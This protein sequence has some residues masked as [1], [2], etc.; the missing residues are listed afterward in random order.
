M[1][2]L[3][4]VRRLTGPNLLWDKPGA[5]VD[6][7]L[8][9][10]DKPEVLAHWNKWIERLLTDFGWQA[11]SHTYRE[12]EHGFNFAIS[13][14]IDALYT[15]C[16]VAELAWHCCASEVQQ[17]ALPDWKERMRALRAELVQEQNPLML[18]IIENAGHHNVSCLFDDDELSL[19]MGAQQDR[20]PVDELPLVDKIDWAKYQ[21]IPCAFITGTNGKST[22]VRLASQIAKAQGICAGV[23]STD[24]IRVGDVIIE[25]GDYSG[26]GGARMLLRDKR[27]EMAFLEVARGGILRRGLPVHHV[28][29]ALI[30]NV[31]SDHLGQYGIY[32]VEALAQT[33]FVVAKALSKDGVLVVNAD[34]DLV[35]QH[36]KTLKNNLCWFSCGEFNS[37]VQQQISTGGRAVFVRSGEV[38]YHQN[39][40]YQAICNI[41]DIPMTLQGAASHNVQN[42]LGVV[43]L[44]KALGLSNEAIVSGLKNFGSDALDNPGRGNIYNINGSQ[45]IVDFAHNE[46][47]M[48]AVVD[49]ARH[50]PANKYVAMFSHAGDRSDQEIF[51]LTDA[52][53][54]LNA[55][56]YIPAEVEKYLR[57]RQPNEV[58][59][60]VQQHLM[61]AN[62]PGQQIMLAASP[63][64]GVKTALAHASP[65]DVVLL[66]VLDQRQE[67]HEWLSHLAD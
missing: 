13:A 53:L 62:V 16:E 45:I 44:C 49:M 21:H 32:T 63:L 25:H 12:H 24:F 47:G 41:H 51:A 66:F 37:E 34:N 42:A 7:L 10:A 33:K 48:K 39:G 29:A 3:D 30:T 28:D 19:G 5:I 55:A 59:S 64:E 65:G 8:T 50:M 36:A 23:T 57:G 38:Y 26:P 17:Q 54:G 43:G 60:L 1:L 67:I 46:H 18:S 61:S 20:W 27:T 52:V 6:V 58:S 31:A 11:Q 15:A 4:E 35:V 14:P 9:E 2:E 56:L 22:C 40:E